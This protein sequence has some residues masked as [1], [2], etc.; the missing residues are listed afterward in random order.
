MV[1]RLIEQESARLESR[2]RELEDAQA[3]IDELTS[4]QQSASARPVEPA[5]PADPARP[6]LIPRDQVV[7]VVR[8]ALTST[9]GPV[10]HAVRS[11]AT[12][13]ARDEALVRQAQAQVLQG[14][15]VQ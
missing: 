8:H 15:V 6:R 11:T 13:P 14:R 10:R 3:L 5:G 2:R 7:A 4:E 12:L 1:G 9:V